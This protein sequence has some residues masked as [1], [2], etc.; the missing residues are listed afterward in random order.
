MKDLSE[1]C[2]FVVVNENRYERLKIRP[3]ILTQFLGL[4]IRPI[5]VP[6]NKNEYKL[7]TLFGELLTH[8]NKISEFYIE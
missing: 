4:L 6:T 8:S 2:D 1:Y 7:F 5:P 3:S